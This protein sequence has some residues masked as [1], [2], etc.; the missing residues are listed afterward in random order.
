MHKRYNV[1][2][3]I[4]RCEIALANAL[5]STIFLTLCVILTNV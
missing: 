1:G 5:M 2:L 4:V 3:V